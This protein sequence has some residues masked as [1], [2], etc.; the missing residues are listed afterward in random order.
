M[1]SEITC[2]VS[3][4]EIGSLNDLKADFTVSLVPANWGGWD[5]VLSHWCHDQDLNLGFLGHNEKV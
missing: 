1:R 5:Y 3:V 2:I 4:D